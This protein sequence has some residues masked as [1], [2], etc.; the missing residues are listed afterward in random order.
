MKKKKRRKEKTERESS[1]DK[2]IIKGT[3]NER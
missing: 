1:K 2:N 3:K